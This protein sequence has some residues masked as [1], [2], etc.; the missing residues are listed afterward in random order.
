M[1][2][3]TMTVEIAN[4]HWFLGQDPPEGA[5]TFKTKSEQLM[6]AFSYGQ[7][8]S[9]GEKA[10]VELGSLDY[11][12]EWEVIFSNNSQKEKKLKKGQETWSYE[13]YGEIK[14]IKPVI[15]DFGDIELDTGNWTNDEKVIGEFVYWK[16]DRLDI[17]KT[18]HNTGL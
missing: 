18:G 7:N 9:V 14:S 4:V 1:P 12:L 16:I 13:G 6:D 17:L 3:L 5:V 2:N 11:D 10:E 15:I 8:F